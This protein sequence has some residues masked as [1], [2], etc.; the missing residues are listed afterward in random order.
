ML[1]ATNPPREMSA[2][3]FEPR[4]LVSTL[5]ERVSGPQDAATIR[6]VAELV[7]RTDGIRKE[8]VD[9]AH[10]TL[11]ALSRQLQS[12]KEA[13][14]DPKHRLDADQHAAKMN[15]LEHERHTVVQQKSDVEESIG[16]L[17]AELMQLERELQQ[18]AREE[19]EEA[20]LPPTKEELTLSIF[21]G[22]GLEMQKDAQGKF[23]KCK[24]LR[25][26]SQDIEIHEFDDKFSRFFYA[27]V[28]WEACL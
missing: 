2:V 10:A 25:P 17:E 9:D 26:S 23:V 13:A 18:L 8:I 15:A 20:N 14:E 1:A 28:L 11:K 19:D 5:L 3:F 21:K 12:A 24:V 6:E 16:A 7:R 27:N 4:D 22:L